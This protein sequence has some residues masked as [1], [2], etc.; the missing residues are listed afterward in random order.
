MSYGYIY[1]II[2][3]WNHNVYVGQKMGPPEKTLWYYG[4]GKIISRVITKRKHLLEKRILGCCNTKEELSE[5]EKICIE[6]FN[7]QNPIYGYNITAGGCGSNGCHLSIE[8]KQKIA[9]SNRT[10]KISKETKQKIS[11]A[12]SGKVRSEEFKENRRK[13]C[14]GRFYSEE[15][16]RKIGDGHKG[17]QHSEK[18]KKQISQHRK[19]KAVGKDNAMHGITMIERLI[20]KYGE[21]LG[22]IRY[23]QWKDHLRKN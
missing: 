5:A 9:N 18:S 8:H 7:S 20:N 10:R 21:E 22:K 3:H 1:L 6:F 16:R 4:S 23:Q 13:I 11:K 15:T 17:M 14:T 2:D 12:N 19:G